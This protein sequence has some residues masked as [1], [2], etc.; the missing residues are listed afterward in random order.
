MEEDVR[1]LSGES[2]REC[3]CLFY[4]FATFVSSLRP[5]WSAFTNGMLGSFN[6]LVIRKPVLANELLQVWIALVS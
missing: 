2:V 6:D 4:F 5:A 1:Y 3:G